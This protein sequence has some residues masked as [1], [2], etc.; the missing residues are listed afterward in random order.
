MAKITATANAMPA[1]MSQKVFAPASQP[2]LVV[3]TSLELPAHQ[4]STLFP[5]SMPAP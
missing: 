1:G 4:S 3:A 2:S 5:T